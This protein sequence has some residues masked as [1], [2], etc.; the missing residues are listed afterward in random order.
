[1][2]D[3]T[4]A[5]VILEALGTLEVLAVRASDLVVQGLASVLAAQA[6]D[7]VLAVHG[8]GD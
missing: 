5:L 3:Y 8:A 4:M 2:K 6:S 1:M 7:L